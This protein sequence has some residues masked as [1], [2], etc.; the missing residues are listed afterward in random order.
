MLR[1]YDNRQ[2]AKSE[3]LIL[4]NGC[5]AFHSERGTS[6][7]WVHNQEQEGSFLASGKNL[8]HFL[9]FFIIMFF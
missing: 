7:K 4:L 5:F 1:F 6:G 3:R 8:S 9:I 2:M